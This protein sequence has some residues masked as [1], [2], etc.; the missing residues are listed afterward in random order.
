MLPSEK[1]LQDW[2]RKIN[3]ART[4]FIV[5]YD[6]YKMLTSSRAHW[7]LRTFGAEDV[8]I[9]NGTYQDWKK[10]GFPIDEKDHPS[11]FKIERDNSKGSFDFKLNQD[12]VVS[13]DWIKQNEQTQE[14]KVIDARG[15]AD[16]AKGHIK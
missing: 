13:Y 11:A 16:Y 3:V 12:M 14:F 5:V 8:Y 15:P 9:L 6:Q 1:D 7:M 10:Q 2:M 4:D